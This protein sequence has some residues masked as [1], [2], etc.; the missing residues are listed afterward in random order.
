MVRV[1]A[2]DYGPTTLSTRLALVAAA[3]AFLTTLSNTT[4][5]V[6]AAAG[7][8]GVGAGLVL[9]SQRIA[10]GGALALVGGVALA[11]VAHDAVAIPLI[12]A[13]AAVLA[14][15]L[16][17]QAL[18]VGEQL[19]RAADTRRLEAVHAGT[20]TAVGLV[21]AGVGF[22][23]YRIAFRGISL[24]ALALLLVAALFLMLSVRE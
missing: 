14:W 3:L 6:L 10:D 16:S 17:E 21:A 19:G 12:G 1:S 7:A 8:V 5:A 20:T 23:L 18:S 22:A 2:P 4:G 15:D 9:P 24:A 11:A 13:V